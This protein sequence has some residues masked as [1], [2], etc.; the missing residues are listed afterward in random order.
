MQDKLKEKLGGIWDT[1][2]EKWEGFTGN[3]NTW[4]VKLK[5][6]IGNIRATLGGVWDTAMTKWEEFKEKIKTGYK[7]VLDPIVE[8]LKTGFNAIKNTFEF[9]SSL[10]SDI[11]STAGDLLGDAIGIATSAVSG[12]FDGGGGATGTTATGGGGG[13]AST[14]NI[15]VNAGGITDRTDKREL[16]R[17]IGNLIQQE[18][19]RG[20]GGSTMSGRM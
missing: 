18:V 11:V 20:Q 8:G 3:I 7:N 4:W 14:Y 12:F 13:G 6:T 1:A 15:T 16:A 2:K 10:I 9:I 19:S 17:E 5:G